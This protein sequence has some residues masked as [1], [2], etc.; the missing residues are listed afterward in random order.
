MTSAF[1]CTAY[2]ASRRE[3]A[4]GRADAVAKQHG[5]TILSW[6][7]HPDDTRMWGRESGVL[8]VRFNAL[9]QVSQA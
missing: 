4:E 5:W 9:A 1:R 2:P 3:E 7:W 6:D 8:V